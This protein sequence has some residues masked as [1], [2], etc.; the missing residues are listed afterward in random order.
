MASVVLS[1]LS[2]I[3]TSA[4]PG[5]GTQATITI[6]APGTS[7]IGSITFLPRIIV[8]A[9]HG[10]IAATTA[11]QTAIYLNLIDGTTGGAAVK[12]S[13]VLAVGTSAKGDLGQSP[14]NIPMTPGGACTLEW[15]SAPVAGALATVSISGYIQTY[16]DP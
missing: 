15:S 1:P 2:V 13:G 6:A 4:R 3:G 12:W 7:T 9:L 10:A 11:I 8:T 14:L 5:I 16:G